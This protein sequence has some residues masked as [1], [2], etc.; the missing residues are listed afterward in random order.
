MGSM[1]CLNVGW[2]DTT[3]IKSTHGTF[4]VDCYNIGDYSVNL[5]ED[6]KIR[7]IFITHQHADHYSGLKYLKDNN[8]SID[9]L[10][11]SPYS[12]RLGDNSVTI[13]E[14]NEFNSLKDYFVS[15]GTETRAP[16]RQDNLQKAWWDMTDIK[17]WI[18]GPHSSVAN[19]QTREIH[20]ASLVIEADLGARICLF[21]GDAS[22]TNLEYIANTT[23]NY[24]NDILHASHHGSMNGAHLEFIKKANAKYTLL[25]T[26]TGVYDNSPH[27]TAL[28]RYKDNTEHNVRRTDVDG[29]WHWTF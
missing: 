18:I 24:C 3:I 28:N 10:I 8:Y 17:F 20:D 15:K 25:S 11:Y 13:E 14:W 12:R 19:T 7:G 5:P 6:K 21:T 23:K 26:K 22:D 29:T 1:H 4:L 2:G 9:F 16:Y 27:P